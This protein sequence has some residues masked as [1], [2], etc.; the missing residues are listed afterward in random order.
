MTIYS[1]T[2]HPSDFYVYAYVRKDGTPYY[3]GKG[4]NKRA[5]DKATH[6]VKVPNND[7]IIIVEHRLTE[8]GALAIERRLIRWY[9]RKDLGTGI[10]R[11]KTDGGDGFSNRSK[12]ALAAISRAKTLWHSQNDIT[13]TNNP[14][15][16]NHWNDEQRIA[17]RNRALAQGFIGNRKG[18]VPANKGIPMSE[19]QKIKLRKPKPKVTCGCCGKEMAPHILARFHGAKCKLA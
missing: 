1:R 16:G 12:K 19:E 13:G 15:F 17:A 9:G 8:I 11:N 7:R 14:N 18:S 10:L 4:K 5:W 2:K 6:N 3:I